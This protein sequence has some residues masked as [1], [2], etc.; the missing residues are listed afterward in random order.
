MATLPQTIDEYLAGL[1][2]DVRDALED[3]RRVIKEAAPD[4][5]ESISYRVP[6]FRVGSPVVAFGVAKHHCSLY[7]MSPPLVA[8]MAD[9]LAPYRVSGATIHFTPSEP[10]P[11]ALVT[12]LVRARIEENAARRS[13]GSGAGSVGASSG[14]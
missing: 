13:E 2:D 1:P 8:S 9:E 11:A 14:A 7:V 4:A 12:R 10:L 3:L 6:T 5:V